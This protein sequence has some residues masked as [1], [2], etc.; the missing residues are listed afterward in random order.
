MADPLE[1]TTNKCVIFTNIRTY[2]CAHNW[3]D[4][5]PPSAQ[6]VPYWDADPDWRIKVLRVAIENALSALSNDDP[7][8]AEQSLLRGL[9]D[10]E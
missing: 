9:A 7:Q 6:I 2:K 1:Q 10:A 3:Q 8:A 5:I 4:V